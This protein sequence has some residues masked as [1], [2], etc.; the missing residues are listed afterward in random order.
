MDPG[1]NTLA[2]DN[3]HDR[4]AI[5]DPA[6]GDCDQIKLKVGAGKVKLGGLSYES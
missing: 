6:T 3:E 5:C 4:L 2:V 1:G